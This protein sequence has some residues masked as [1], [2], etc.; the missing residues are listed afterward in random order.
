MTNKITEELQKALCKELGTEYY[1]TP[2]DLKVGISLNVRDGVVPI[3][4]L[5]HSPE[6]D[7]TGWYIYAGEELPDSPDFFNL[8][9]LST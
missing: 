5:R 3:N 8:Y 2:R 1:P 6:G 4:G 9:M 7:T